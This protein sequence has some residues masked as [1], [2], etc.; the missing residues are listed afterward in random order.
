M[1]SYKYVILGGGLTAGYAVQEFAKKGIHSGELCIV[2]AEEMLPYERPPL[3]KDFLA[4]K[5]TFDDILI[6]EPAF[7]EENKIELKLGTAVT[8]VDLDKK[9]LYT[10]DEAITY[11]KLL[12]ATGARPHTFDLPGAD[13]DNIFYLRKVDDARQIRKK[14]QQAEKA[15]VIGGSFIAMEA[16]AVLQSQGVETTMIFPEERV[17]Q[18]FFTPQ[19]SAFFEKYYRD[20]GVTIL[21]EQKIDSFVGEGKVAHVVTQVGE[22]LPADM[23]VAGIGV[24]ANS[25]LF[26]DSAL[27][28]DADDGTICVNHYLQTNMPDVLAA[29]DVTRYPSTLY[30][31][32]LHTEHW[33]N[34][35]AQGRHAACVMLG[36]IQPFEH[37]P[38]FFSDVFDLS[39]E[40]WGDTEGAAEAVHRGSVEE[41]AFSTWWLAGDGRLLAA[42]VMNRPDEE[43][44]LVPKWIKSGK[45]LSADWL[46][47]SESLQIKE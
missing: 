2:S 32:T 29:G 46:H 14:A 43:R 28:L 27:Q 19:M 21:P 7:Y 39:Y 5:K 20:R 40:F 26:A 42:F 22:K 36:E 30:D 47:S 31:R 16:T 6:N 35:V 34:A 1:G 4:G 38:Y 12:I 33:D 45:K 23:V 3:S 18:A 44:E 9:Q 10:A 8:R 15:V 41:G 25:D 11:E 37:V 13:L 24:T 17:W